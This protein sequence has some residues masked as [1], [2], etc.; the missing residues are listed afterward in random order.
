[1]VVVR[2]TFKRLFMVIR[3][4]PKRIVNS[5]FASVRFRQLRKVYYYLFKNLSIKGNE[6]NF[7]T[8]KECE[9]ECGLSQVAG[10]F[11]I[12]EIL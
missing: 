8:Q 1:M 3:N 7:K 6:N 2:V 4:Y 11:N 12:F 5:G 10:E 9:S